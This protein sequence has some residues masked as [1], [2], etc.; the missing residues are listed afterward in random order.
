M[1]IDAI[2]EFMSRE[3]FHPFRIRASSGKSYLVTNPSLVVP[4]KS[5]VFIAAP[6]S[7]K[8]A[9]VPYL[10]VASVEGMGNGHSKRAPT[11]KPR[12]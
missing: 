3:P 6:N 4:M 11:R 10:H 12:R 8:F 1:I 2:R 9:T 7:D 5:W